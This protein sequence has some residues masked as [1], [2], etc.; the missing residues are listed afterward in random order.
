MWWKWKAA[1]MLCIVFIVPLSGCGNRPDPEE[2]TRALLNLR[3]QGTVDELAELSKDKSRSELVEEYETGIAAFNEAY[4]TNG[5]E[6]GDSM[7]SQYYDLCRELFRAMRYHVKDAK[8]V[9]KNE[10]QVMVEVTTSDIFITYMPKLK[11]ESRKIQ[12]EVNR[13]EFTG[14]QEEINAQVMQDFSFRAYQLL[15]DSYL[16]MQY[17]DKKTIEL[18]VK[19]DENGNYTIPEEEIW[20]FVLKILA[21]DEIQG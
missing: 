4:L 2:F 12:E 19:I 5:M 11:E 6:M 15:K 17:K 1:I 21:I 9:G 3:M 13:G 18:P 20:N 14:N 16:N 7:N 8:K 10:Y